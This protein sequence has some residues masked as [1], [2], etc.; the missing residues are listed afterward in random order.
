MDTL[1]KAQLKFLRKTSHNHKPLFQMGKLGLT[2]AFIDQVDGALD[3]REV[4]KFHLLQ[5]SDEDLNEVTQTI[6]D[7]VGAHI[8]QVI[9]STAILYRESSK[10]KF[11]EI[12]KEVNKLR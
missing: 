11:Q 4:L 3:K 9:G 2:E 6:A 12:S 10:D 1:N 5:N 8:V 7:H